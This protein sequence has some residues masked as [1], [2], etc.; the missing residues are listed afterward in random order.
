MTVLAAAMNKENQQPTNTNNN[1]NPQPRQQRGPPTHNMGRYCYSCGF[2]PV[3]LGHKSQTCKSKHKK[4]DHKSDTKWSNWMGGRMTWPKKNRVTTKQQEHA[5]YKGQSAPTN[6]QGLGIT[7]D[8]NKIGSKTNIEN[9]LTSNYYA[10]LSSLP[11]QV[12]DHKQTR[13]RVAFKNHQNLIINTAGN[14]EQNQSTMGLDSPE[15]KR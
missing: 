1:K 2:H 9:M 8:R 6:W 4:Q 5:T 3:G 15:K 11:C 14:E 7:C 10:C 12:E 13:T